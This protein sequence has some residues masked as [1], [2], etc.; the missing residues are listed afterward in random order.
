METHNKS[1]ESLIV[2]GPSLE[3]DGRGVGLTIQRHGLLE[4][5]MIPHKWCSLRKKA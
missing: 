2:E 1:S 4:L 5:S 3:H